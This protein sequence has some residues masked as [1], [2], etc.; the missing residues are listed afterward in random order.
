[1]RVIDYL[2]FYNR[3]FCMRV[4][5]YLMF[6]SRLFC[7]C[8]LSFLQSSTSSTKSLGITQSLTPAQLQLLQQ[9]AAAQAAHAKAQAE[10]QA[11]KA[12]GTKVQVQGKPLLQGKFQ[13]TKY[14]KTFK[15][16]AFSL[17]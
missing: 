12:P 8:I 13:Q 9:A 15:I 11:T 10:A 2:M 6:Y 17:I 14:S 7:Q 3:L 1:M 4:I 5:D 16:Q